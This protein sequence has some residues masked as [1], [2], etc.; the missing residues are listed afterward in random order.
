[1]TAL[2]IGLVDLLRSF[3]V[4]PDQ[5][6][7]HSSG[8]IGAAYTIGAISVS[9]AMQ[10]AYF[11]GKFS[12]LLSADLSHQGAMMAVALSEEEVKTYL[13]ANLAKANGVVVGCFNSSKSVTLSGPKSQVTALEVIFREAD[14]FARLLKVPVAYHSPQMS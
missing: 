12:D 14:I 7:G 3:E 6:V 11:R 10:L 5:V 9:S 2:Q 13:Q 1:C 8:E 4:V